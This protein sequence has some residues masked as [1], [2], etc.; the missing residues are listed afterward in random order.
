[1]KRLYRTSDFRLNAC[2]NYVPEKKQRL[3]RGLVF[4]FLGG[5]GIIYMHINTT[6][7]LYIYS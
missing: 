7:F 5:G 4:F 1:M 3:G 2:K 6:Y